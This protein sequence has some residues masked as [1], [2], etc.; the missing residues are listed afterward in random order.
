MAAPPCRAP[1]YVPALTAE[2]A[3]GHGGRPETPVVERWPTD[4]LVLSKIDA[5][6]S[7]ARVATATRDAHRGP[8]LPKADGDAKVSAKPHEDVPIAVA[9]VIE[10]SLAI[11]Q[12][13][14]ATAEALHMAKYDLLTG[15]LPSPIADIVVLRTLA[16]RFLNG[17][18]AAL[19]VTR[20]LALTVRSAETNG[21]VTAWTGQEGGLV[22]RASVSS[23]VGRRRGPE[24][25][26]YALRTAQVL[27]GGVG[28]VL[29]PRVAVP[30][31]EVASAPTASLPA[32]LF[33]QCT[34]RP[35]SDSFPPF[36]R[37][38]RFL[39]FLELLWRLADADE[40]ELCHLTR[41]PPV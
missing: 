9:C 10:P 28:E 22:S 1:T 27:L 18:G 12:G 21:E 3:V 14:P 32:S 26:T 16:T 13:V 36:Y 24:A 38:S 5:S 15:R 4:D 8:I 25:P 20:G 17:A 29:V 37:N 33:V 19:L 31:A 39:V 11:A 30:V 41:P 34:L 35:S 7:V 40:W 6:A 2:I 23:G